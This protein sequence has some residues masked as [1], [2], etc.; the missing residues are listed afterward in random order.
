MPLGRFFVAGVAGA[1]P[2]AAAVGAA[3]GAAASGRSKPPIC[4]GA[5]PMVKSS[6]SSRAIGPDRTTAEGVRRDNHRDERRLGARRRPN[7]GERNV[8][9]N[10]PNAAARNAF[11]ERSECSGFVFLGNSHRR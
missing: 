2:S 7:K 11:P 9:G 6:G 5:S 10:V 8:H 1:P 4:S 3:A